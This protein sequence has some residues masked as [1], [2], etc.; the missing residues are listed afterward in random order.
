MVVGGHLRIANYVPIFGLQHSIVN[1]FLKRR[2][3]RGE[4]M[5]QF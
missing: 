5:Y 3:Q 1:Y 4:N 2:F